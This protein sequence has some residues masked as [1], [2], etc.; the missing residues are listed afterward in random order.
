MGAG[1]L[2]RGL[3]DDDAGLFA[4]GR[5]G[6]AYDLDG[7]VFD[8]RDR[9]KLL[10]EVRNEMRKTHPEFDLKLIYSG[11]R[12]GTEQQVWTDLQKAVELR[13]Q[14]ADKNFL[15]G[16]D[17]VGEE[18]AGWTTE[19]FLDDWVKLRG[20][21]DKQKTSLPLYFHDGESDQPSD[22]NLYDAFLLGTRRVGHGFN[23]FRFPVLERQFTAR[24]IAVEVCP[25]SNQQ[26][27]YVADLRV[28]PAC[29]Y[30][31]RGVPM[32]LSNDDP[33][34]FRNDGLSF[35]FWEAVMA[36]ELDLRGAK[37]LARNSIA[38]SGMTTEERERALTDWQ[39]R[40]NAWVEKTAAAAPRRAM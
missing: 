2:P 39:H 29:G 15:I 17:L 28:H 19:H 11:Y 6:A 36:W 25:I 9:M 40:W 16:F 33:G 10:W 38:F 14:W 1:V 12:R 24:G 23:L 4:D 22:D 30:L 34:I 18:D 21:L 27:R 13:Q 32:V 37:Q 5:N 8:H 26:L 35:D 31:T 3:V 7:R 20:L